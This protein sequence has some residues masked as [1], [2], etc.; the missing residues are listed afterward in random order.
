MRV[1]RGGCLG[2][3]SMSARRK[4]RVVP[5][6]LSYITVIRGSFQTTNRNMA[7]E[8]VAVILAK[9][10]DTTRIQPLLSTVEHL[11]HTDAQ[12]GLT[13][14]DGRVRVDVWIFDPPQRA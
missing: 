11:P 13:Q 6:C 3:R 4:F 5:P 12:F 9:V 2:V 8:E 1:L 10:L 14:L 7:E